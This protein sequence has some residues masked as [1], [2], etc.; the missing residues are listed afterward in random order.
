MYDGP[1]S[2][3]TTYSKASPANLQTLC[4]HVV[5]NRLEDLCVRVQAGA[6]DTPFP[7]VFPPQFTVLRFSLNEVTKAPPG[8]PKARNHTVTRKALHLPKTD[9]HGSQA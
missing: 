7:D 6:T 1:S 2:V 4:L 9:D 5:C 3:M 8:G